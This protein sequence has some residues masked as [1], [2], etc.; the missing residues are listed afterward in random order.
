MWH[1]VG[2]M[3][4]LELTQFERFYIL[5]RFNSEVAIINRVVPFADIRLV[6]PCLCYHA[7]KVSSIIISSQGLLW[8]F[9][10]GYQFSCTHGTLSVYYEYITQKV[11]IKVVMHVPEARSRFFCTVLL[12]GFHVFIISLNSRT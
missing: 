4:Y 5:S 10:N 7:L 2:K 6:V 3:R 12:M 8:A 9:N 11:Q 1:W